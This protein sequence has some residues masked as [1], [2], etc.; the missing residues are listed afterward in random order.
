MKKQKILVITNMYPSAENKS[1]GIF[2][3]NQADAL[4]KRGLT[5]DVVS[6]QN[7][8]GGKI[9]VLAKYSAWLLKTVRV[10]LAQ[11][12]RYD[13]VHAHYVFPSGSLGLLFKRLFGT[14]LIVT[15]HGGDIDKMA[16][17]SPFI[18]QQTAKI[19]ANADHVIAVGEELHK[20]ITEE[21]SVDKGRISIINMGVDR[22]VFHRRDKKAAKAN[23]NIADSEMPLLFV[24]NI[25]KQKGL[26]ELVEAVSIAA[27][28]HPDT[29]LYII[30]AEKDPAFKQELTDHVKLLD[31]ENRVFFL[32]VRTQQ[33]I[34][35]WMSAAEVFILPS[36]IEGFGLV[37]LEAMACG[38]PVIG[39]EAG[40]L[41]HLLSNGAG[42][43][44]PVKNA[45]A[46]SKGIEELLS[47]PEKRNQQILIG[48][49]KAEENDQDRMLDRVMKVYFPTGG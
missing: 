20:T 38:T 27:E 12:K 36:H 25:I 17:K 39:T 30:G 1:F 6:I 15:S 31:M 40:G 32:G 35:E 43:I 14:R 42:E 47:S 49:K 7:P 16:R 10:L 13:I 21:F 45:A 18:H 23:C 19:L 41:K 3:K 48:E 44:V 34:A 37:A 9:K 8:A 11:G 5:V 29:T 2:V 26:L 4:R 33:E 24:G 22:D 28:S 46:L